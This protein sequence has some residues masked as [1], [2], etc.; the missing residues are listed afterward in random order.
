MVE[1]FRNIAGPGVLWLR[2]FATIIAHAREG[3]FLRR[4]PR[5]SVPPIGK[6]LLR[7][8]FSTVSDPP[9]VFFCRNMY[10]RFGIDQ[11]KIVTAE[12]KSS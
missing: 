1:K 8:F 6:V 5:N 3:V 10:A 2:P 7:V 9:M 11:L 4:L 12:Q